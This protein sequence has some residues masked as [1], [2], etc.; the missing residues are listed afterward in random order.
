MIARGAL[1]EWGVDYS[2]LVPQ[3]QVDTRILQRYE[4]VYTSTL[5]AEI[6]VEVED[7]RLYREL[8]DTRFELH[9]L[10]DA[11]FYLQE[12]DVRYNFR[13]TNSGEVSGIQIRQGSLL[14]FVERR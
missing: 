6:T 12:D 1:D 8:N 11:E 2:E 5:V 4:G 14:L 10:S 13:M 3:L 7:G 9:P